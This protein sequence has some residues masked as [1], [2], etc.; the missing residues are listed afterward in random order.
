[1]PM[2]DGTGL[3]AVI[4]GS[5]AVTLGLNSLLCGNIC[6]FDRYANTAAKSRT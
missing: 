2:L 6:E 5:G 1:M 4:A 3:W